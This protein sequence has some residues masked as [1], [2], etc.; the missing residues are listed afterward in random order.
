[1]KIISY[2]FSV[3]IYGLLKLAYMMI[4]IDLIMF[5]IC[6]FSKFIIQNL[7]YGMFVCFK[8]S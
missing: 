1:M 4:F 7:F 3:S 6:M 2:K 5:I 8:S